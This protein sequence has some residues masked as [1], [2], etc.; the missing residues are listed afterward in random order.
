LNFVHSDIKSEN[1]GIIET[2][3]KV[4]P[5]LIDFGFIVKNGSE[6]CKE[7]HRFGTHIP[8]YFNKY[9]CR[10]QNDLYSYGVMLLGVLFDV[11]FFIDDTEYLI[12]EHENKMP[13][14]NRILNKAFIEY[15]SERICKDFTKL[16]DALKIQMKDF[17]QF[18][19]QIN[20]EPF[21]NL[22]KKLKKENPKV[23]YNITFTPS[24]LYIRLI[25][26]PSVHGNELPFCK[27]CIASLLNSINMPTGHVP[28]IYATIKENIDPWMELDKMT[29]NRGGKKKRTYKKKR[30]YKRSLKKYRKR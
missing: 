22:Y 9:P 10:P 7:E 24:R 3:G 25:T 29:G 27:I 30:Y 18:F 11:V 21:P 17:I 16:F 26:N 5:F 20:T 12:T 23:E 4:E 1:V 19:Q 8:P 14:I 13:V 28:S 2:G 6:K 15:P